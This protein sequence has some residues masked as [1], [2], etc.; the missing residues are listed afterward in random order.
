MW[1][2]KLTVS[3]PF[4]YIEGQVGENDGGQQVES[5]GD[6]RQSI[7]SN[8]APGFRC[9]WSRG[10]LLHRGE[11]CLCVHLVERLDLPLS[12]ATPTKSKK[13]KRHYQV[14]DKCVME[15]TARSYHIVG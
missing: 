3:I 10:V 4:R 12:L 15:T 5:R 2:C 13:R 1:D 14:L 7:Q 9:K 11:S 8:P 6:A